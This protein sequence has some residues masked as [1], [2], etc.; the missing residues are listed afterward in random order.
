MAQDLTPYGLRAVG[1]DSLLDQVWQ[2]ERLTKSLK[3]R[4]DDGVG[5]VVRNGGLDER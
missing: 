5:A 2:C 3:S 4:G 1:G